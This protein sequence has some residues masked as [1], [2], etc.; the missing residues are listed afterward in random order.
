MAA[1][2]LMCCYCFIWILAVV[3]LNFRCTTA[4]EP[5]DNNEWIA[6]AKNWDYSY[7]DHE[8]VEGYC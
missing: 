8:T 6:N 1:K 3:E 4:Q 2:Q 7:I 5:C